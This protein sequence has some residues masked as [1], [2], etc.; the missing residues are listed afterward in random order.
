MIPF[1][2]WRLYP[3]LEPDEMDVPVKDPE[4]TSVPKWSRN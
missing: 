4:E 1:G 3:H 2:N